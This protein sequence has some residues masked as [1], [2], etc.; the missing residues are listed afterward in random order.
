[1]PNATRTSAPASPPPS[2]EPHPFARGGHAQT[3]IGRY[4]AGRRFDLDSVAHEVD[5]GDGDRLCVLESASPGWSAGAPAAVLIHGLAGDAEAWY[6]VRLA[7][8]LLELGVRVV[9]MNLRGAGGGFGLARG[10]YHSGR[11]GDVGVVVDW[12]ADRAPGSPVAVA[13]FSLGASLALRLASEA[14]APAPAAL[15]C[16]VA[17]NP[18]LDLRACALRMGERGNRVYDRSFAR[19]LRADIA[20]LHQRFPDLGPTG[21]DGVRSIYEF[22]DRYTAPRNGFASAEDYYARCAA[23]P[24]L[25]GVRVPGLIVHAADDPFIPVESFLDATLPAN[26]ELDLQPAGGHMGFISRDPW[27]GDRRWLETRLAD[28]LARRWGLL[29]PGERGA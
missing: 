10:I 6:L 22:D 29:S 7:G 1:M 19:W 24:V 25:G 14:D 26:I 5:L 16:V 15:D 20:R 11:A 23:G 28:W 4:L 12:L 21:L 13:G 17:A 8:R 3:I 9:R 2:F 18:P 27:R